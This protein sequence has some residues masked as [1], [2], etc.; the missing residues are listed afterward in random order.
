MD[1]TVERREGVRPRH[2]LGTLSA[3]SPATL[4]H[5]LEGGGDLPVRGDSLSYLALRLGACAWLRRVALLHLSCPVSHH[6]AQI[7][8][9]FFAHDVSLS[10]A[11]GEGRW[12]PLLREDS[13]W[14][15]EASAL[16]R[17]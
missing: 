3:K 13:R 7:S 9:P 2:R 6:T 5:I 14:L 16:N 1:L 17:L 4:A 8:S 12:G 10:V 11:Y 15:G